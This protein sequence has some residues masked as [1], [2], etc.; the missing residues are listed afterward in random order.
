MNL[1]GDAASP[2]FCGA[3]SEGQPYM[4]M[5]GWV[6]N[7]PAVGGIGAHKCAPYIM[8]RDR[9]ECLDWIPGLRH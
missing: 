9:A 1:R 4:G 6:W 7:Y 5:R 8:M 3:G 2:A